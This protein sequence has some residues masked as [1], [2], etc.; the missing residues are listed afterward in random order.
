MVVLSSSLS[1]EESASYVS[2]LPTGYQ[3]VNIYVYSKGKA[4]H[5]M[6]QEVS[7]EMRALHRG[8]GEQLTKSSQP[9]TMNCWW[10]CKLKWVSNPCSFIFFPSVNVEEFSMR[11]FFLVFPQVSRSSK[12]NWNRG[13]MKDPRKTATV[14]NH[15]VARATETK[16]KQGQVS[17][18]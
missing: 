4:K 6:L 13:L 16:L 9:Y 8:Q 15:S 10:I 7:K 12:P 1:Y 2:F 14:T 5:R 17:G 11:A 18:R 3:Q